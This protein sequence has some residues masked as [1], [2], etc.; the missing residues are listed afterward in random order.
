MDDFEEALQNIDIFCKTLVN[1]MVQDEENSGLIVEPIESLLQR[2]Y[3]IEEHFESSPL[4]KRLIPLPQLEEPLVDVFEE[5]DYVRVLMQCRCKEKIVTV[6]TDMDG[7]KICRKECRTDADGTQIC[8]DEC[9][10][11]DL[12]VEHLQIENMTVKCNNNK[13]FEVSIPKLKHTIS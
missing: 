7:V 5:D 13:V 12:S 1:K 4:E 10:R 8:R 6:H 11:L 3:I 9:Q 2:K